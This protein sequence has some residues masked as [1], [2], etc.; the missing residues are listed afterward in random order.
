MLDIERLGDR[1]LAGMRASG[2]TPQRQV[3]L[4]EFLSEFVR[5]GYCV[6]ESA[7]EFLETLY[8]LVFEYEGSDLMG[9]LDFT[10]FSSSTTN[11]LNCANRILSRSSAE[12]SFQTLSDY[13]H[14]RLMPIATS[15]DSYVL[16]SAEA[17]VY[18][19]DVGWMGLVEFGSIYHILNC[20]HC[21]PNPTPAFLYFPDEA[22]PP[23]FRGRIDPSFGFE[24]KP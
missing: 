1:A 9:Y 3:D 8:D 17:R 4:T 18:L 16:Y 6:I 14:T 24:P 13:L 20:L 11:R 5:H 22:K 15:N 7:S 2:W 10:L 19:L 12:I 21:D 23:G